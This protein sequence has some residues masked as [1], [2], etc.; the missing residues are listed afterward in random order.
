MITIAFFLER[1]DKKIIEKQQPKPL[2]DEE[3][4]IQRQEIR[5]QIDQDFKKYYAKLFSDHEFVNKDTTTLKDLIIND[6]INGYDL[7]KLAYLNRI[8]VEMAGGWYPIT[9]ELMRELD[10][11]GWN[12]KVGSI[13]EK[14]GELRFYASTE[15]EAL[16]DK[17][18]ELSRTICE[19]CGEPGEHITVGV[20]DQTLCESCQN[21]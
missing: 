9:V 13:K 16:L 11:E 21:E 15:N 7:H 2:T 8:K 20:W 10:K 12:R 18:T 19:F 4:A 3:R 6:D 1:R 5:K 17:Y 14:F